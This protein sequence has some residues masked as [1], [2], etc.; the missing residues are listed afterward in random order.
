MIVSETYLLKLHREV[1]GLRA[2]W[3]C[4]FPG[5]PACGKDLNPHH[6]FGRG[7]SL[8][9]DPQYSI[10]LCTPH[11]TG[12]RPS[13]HLTPNDFE[14]IIRV[15]N[16]RTAQWFEEGER[17]SNVIVKNTNDIRLWW[18]KELLRQRV[19]LIK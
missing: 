18:K 4:E 12:E 1:T 8:L 6:Q 2:G 15:A 13:A 10:W 5:C 3:K 9:F 7:Y 14:I 17:L 19:E 11:H 16:V